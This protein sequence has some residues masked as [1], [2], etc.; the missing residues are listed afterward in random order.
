MPLDWQKLTELTQGKEV[1]IER[2]RLTE[3]AI[4]IDGHFELPPLA[5]L[6]V[7]DQVFVIA[8]IR[9]HGSIK[10]MEQLF[11]VSYPTIKNRLNRIALQFE[12]VEI[13]QEPV[14]P[15]PAAHSESAAD[16]LESLNN[17]DLSA[18]QAIEALRR[19]KR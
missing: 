19:L 9:T 1:E 12:Y 8:F 16:I 3:S 15:A 11:G 10:E 7:E 6:T 17:G 5:R 14:T 4:A 2:V 13:K 18:A